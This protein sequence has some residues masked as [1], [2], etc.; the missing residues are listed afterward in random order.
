MKISAKFEKAFVEKSSIN[1]EVILGEGY[2]KDPKDQVLLEQ[3]R[4]KKLRLFQSLFLSLNKLFG[5]KNWMEIENADF[6]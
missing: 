3:Y 2:Y 5:R 4:I 1:E 6:D